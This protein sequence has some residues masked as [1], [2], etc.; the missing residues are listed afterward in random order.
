[1]SKT[2]L[3]YASVKTKKMFSIQGFYRT[4]IEILKKMGLNVKLSSSWIDFF[5]FWKYDISFLYF[6]RYSF[7][8]GLIS[9]F[10]GK[11]VYFTG[12]IDYL[13][14]ENSSFFR[15]TVQRVFFPL[16]YFVSTNCILVSDTDK[17]N[18]KRHFP[19]IKGDKLIL[20]PHSIDSGYYGFDKDV[21]RKKWVVTISWMLSLENVQRKGVDSALYVFNE[22]LQMDNSYKMIIIGP[23]GDG[24]SYLKSIIETLGISASVTFTGP[25]P[26]AEKLM[27]LKNSLFYLQL[28]KYEGFGLA[29]I[30]ALASGCVIMHSNAGGLKQGVGKYG[31]IANEKIESYRQMAEKLTSVLSDPK[32]MIVRREAGLTHI[33]NDFD[34]GV[35]FNA[36]RKLMHIA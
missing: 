30:E 8:A 13:S 26:E 23:T 2:V 32:D 7:F 3:F 29:A 12:G 19:F 31:I 4:D 18:I 6:Y 34:N 5:L 17:E 14:K 1:M 27:Y 22:M 11:K 9:R 33:Q 25:I 16:C 24:T 20:V 28:S 15:F 36:F 35:R 10:Y 21:K